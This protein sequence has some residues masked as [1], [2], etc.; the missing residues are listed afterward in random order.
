MF[1]AFGGFF[2]KERFC[3]EGEGSAWVGHPDMITSHETYETRVWPQCRISASEFRAR[4]CALEPICAISCA[5]SH[6]FSVILPEYL[7]FYSFHA[8][9]VCTPILCPVCCGDWCDTNSHEDSHPRPGEGAQGEEG[10]SPQS[11]LRGGLLVRAKVW[12]RRVAKSRNYGMLPT[13]LEC[14]A[15]L[16]GFCDPS[17]GKTAA[18]GT[19]L[20]TG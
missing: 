3:V 5:Y 16:R 4:N 13:L 15:M 20:C 19:N 2:E 10:S 8:Q 11:K 17:L 7:T 1:G 12:S 14:R 6:G 18:E 9:V